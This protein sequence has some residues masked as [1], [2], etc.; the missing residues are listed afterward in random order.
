MREY[1]KSILFS[2]IYDNIPE[3]NLAMYN[4]S[5]KVFNPSVSLV[6]HDCGTSLGN[7]IQ[8]TD[9]AIGQEEAATS[10]VIDKQRVNDLLS[11]G[12]YTVGVRS[13]YTCVSKSGLCQVDYGSTILIDPP[14]V[15]TQITLKPA[16]KIPFLSYLANSYS[17]SLVGFQSIP[18]ENLPV[19][20]GLYN[21]ILSLSELNNL[22]MEVLSNTLIPKT[23]R[24]YF[25]EINDTL[26][27]SLY[28]ITLYCIFNL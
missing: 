21:E 24:D 23:Y 13:P 20:P 22:G 12:I 7:I 15:G 2:G 25:Q 28:L 19:R 11:Q 1:A 6:E 27:K 8:V 9:S 26:E 16:N 14:P 3:S 18:S 10:Q 5:Q 4:F 17:G